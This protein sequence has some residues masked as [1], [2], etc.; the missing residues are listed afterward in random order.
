MLVTLCLFQFRAITKKV[1]LLIPY[2]PAIDV[3]FQHAIA[4]KL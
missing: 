1:T 3:K 2:D 4:M